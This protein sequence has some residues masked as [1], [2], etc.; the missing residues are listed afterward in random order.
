MDKLQNDYFNKGIISPRLTLGRSVSIAAVSLLSGAVLSMLLPEILRY[1]F[2]AL[3]LLLSA[4]FTLFFAKR[5][6]KVGRRQFY[7]VFF[8]FAFGALST[9]LYISAIHRDSLGYDGKTEDVS[10]VATVREVR[11]SNAYSFGAIVDIESIDGKNIRR[12]SAYFNCES[13]IDISV[14]ERF[15]VVCDIESIYQK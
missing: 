6:S 15:T 5:F 9:S 8:A 13:A 4:L 2:I 3:A 14:G 12:T 7:Y 10:L 1:V 11:Y